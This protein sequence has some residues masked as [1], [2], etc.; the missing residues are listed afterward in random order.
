ME[1]GSAFTSRAGWMLAFALAL[2]STWLIGLEWRTSQQHVRA[3]F[4]DIE[5][6]VAFHAVNTTISASLLG[7]AALLMLFSAAVRPGHR[8][9]LLI[10]QAAMFAVLAFDDRFM[11]HE[12]LG[13]RLDVADHVVMGG[14]AMLELILLAA[15]CRP[16]HVSKAAVRLF[17]AGVVLFALMFAFDSVVPRDM[18]LRLSIEDLCK[19]WGAAMF[20]AAAWTVAAAHLEPDRRKRTD[21]V[22]EPVQRWHGAA[23]RSIE[24]PD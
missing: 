13:D 5:G 17:G 16:L 18:A 7:A 22:V 20:F 15:F 6:E 24:R 3:Y 1:R 21:G 11:L 19:T 4:S 10:S 23:R 12:R 9:A 14:W 2:Y 8:R